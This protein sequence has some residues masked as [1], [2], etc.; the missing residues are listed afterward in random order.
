MRIFFYEHKI[1]NISYDDDTLVLQS[2]HYTS[3]RKTWYQ[4]YRNEY[5]N[6]QKLR[7]F[8]YFTF[9]DFKIGHVFV[10]LSLVDIVQIVEILS[11]GLIFKNTGETSTISFHQMAKDLVL[12]CNHPFQ[13]S[14]THFKN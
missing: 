11:T 10:H 6:I 8:G 4:H 9:R 13:Y 2:I 1:V 12:T 5:S 7:M 3:L 14:I